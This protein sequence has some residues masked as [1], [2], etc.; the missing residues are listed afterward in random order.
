MT[1]T[2][3]NSQSVP[4]GALNGAAPGDWLLLSVT[5]LVVWLGCLAIGVLGWVLPY[6]RARVIPSPE[7]PPVVARVMELKLAPAPDPAPAAAAPAK[8]LDQQPPPLPTPLIAP[9]PPAYTVAAPSPQIAFAV[10]VATPA[11]VVAA[12][13]APYRTPEAP[14]VATP[15]APAPTPQVL[16]FGEGD[17]RQALPE[18]PREARRQGQEGVVTV[19]LTV[20]EDGRVLDAGAAQPCPWPLLNHAAL[21][22][23]RSRW[24]FSPGP[25]RLY[26]V[27][28]RFQ[29]N[30]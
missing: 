26:E 16:T 25:V 15:A 21:R 6:A 5:T 20:G 2:V 4:A 7:P 12:S 23:V 22:V 30:K 14:V 29:L 24:R 8:H 27:A 13:Q 18:Y 10:P 9:A 28:I 11:V 17:G 19:R 1:Q 3:A